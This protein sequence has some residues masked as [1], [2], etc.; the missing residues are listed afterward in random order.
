MK[1]LDP[2]DLVA[3]V[4]AHET[5]MQSPD[6]QRP[7]GKA[8]DDVAAA[9][10]ALS[11]STDAGLQEVPAPAS[12]S[13]LPADLLLRL[14]ALDHQL[15]QLTQ[16]VTRVQPGRTSPEEK[17]PR[18]LLA[19]VG[20]PGSYDAPDPARIGVGWRI[21]PSTHARIKQVQA[22]LGLRTLAGTLECVLRL[23]LAAAGRLPR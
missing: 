21:H 18:W 20:D 12:S 19:A 6:W 11:E 9:L 10:A 1:K 2:Q 23:G 7:D 17:I 15:E 14:D 16:A 3:A 22:G 5:W 4:D 8:D 13:S